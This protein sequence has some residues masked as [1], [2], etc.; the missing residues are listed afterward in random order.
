MPQIS[1]YSCN[2]NSDFAKSQTKAKLTEGKR[3]STASLWAGVSQGRVD[4]GEEGLTHWVGSDSRAC[5]SLLA[6]VPEAQAGP[7]KGA[8]PAAADPLG[9]RMSQLIW[10]KHLSLCSSALGMT[11][12]QPCGLQGAQ[13][14]RQGQ[15]AMRVRE[16]VLIHPEGGRR[17][18]RARMSR[19]SPFS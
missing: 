18:P 1:K 9:V 11:S 19:Q 17:Q 4:L 2:E 14:Q 5:L 12:V 10:I 3:V 8:R 7:V 6:G 13:S 15:L 16:E